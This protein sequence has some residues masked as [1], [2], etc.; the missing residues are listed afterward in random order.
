MSKRRSACSD[1][2]SSA[3]Q[4]GPKQAGVAVDTTT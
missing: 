2:E 4:E 3:L 1:A